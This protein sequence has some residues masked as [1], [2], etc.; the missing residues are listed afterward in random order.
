[1]R[2]ACGVYVPAFAW[3]TDQKIAKHPTMLNAIRMA[4]GSFFARAPASV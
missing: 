3:L 4:A 1:M 2:R